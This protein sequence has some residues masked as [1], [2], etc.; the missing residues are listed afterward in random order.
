MS[1]TV[2]STLP[3]VILSAKVFGLEKSFFECFF[4]ICR[5]TDALLLLLLL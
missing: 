3:K 5:L 1:R 4:R 2:L